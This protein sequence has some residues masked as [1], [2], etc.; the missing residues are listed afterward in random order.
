MKTYTVH[1]YNRAHY[2][3]FN[4][5]A[6]DKSAAVDRV[7]HLLESEGAAEE[8]YEMQDFSGDSYEVWPLEDFEYKAHV[9][10]VVESDHSDD[11]QMIDSGGNG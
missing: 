4:V 2:A 9:E 5:S 6:E 3:T 11:L 10:D 7:T 8:E 1:A